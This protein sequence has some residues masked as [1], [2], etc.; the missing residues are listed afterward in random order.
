MTIGLQ[1][2]V[3][4]SLWLIGRNLGMSSGIQYYFIFFPMMWVISSLP[5][6]I[7]GLGILEGGLVLLFVQFTGADEDAA[8]ALALCQ[9]LTWVLASLPGMIVHLVGVHRGNILESDGRRNCPDRD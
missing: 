4:F 3:I 1:S 2:V 9:R 8:K 7:A 5:L 6:S